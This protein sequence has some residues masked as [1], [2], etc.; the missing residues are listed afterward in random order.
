MIRA[1]RYSD[2]AAIKHIFD[3][4]FDDEYR[5]R[6]VDIVKR[7]SRWQQIYPL[8]RI[9]ALFPN[10][11]QDAFNVH[12]FD[13]DGEIRALIQ[14][15]ARNRERT[16]WHI[17]NVAVLP[18]FRGQGVAKKLLDFIFDHYNN[19]GVNRFTLEVDTK[20]ASALRLYEKTGFR[21]Y[22]TVNYY[23]L[24]SSKLTGQL[25]LA[26]DPV[27]VPEGF[28]PHK[29]SDAVQ[30][31]ELYKDSTPSNVRMVDERKLSDFKDH[32]LE[33]V[34]SYIKEQLKY[35]QENHWVVERDAKIVAS[36]EIVAQHRK[37]PH[38]LRLQM[39]PGYHDLYEP[40]LRF[41][42]HHLGQFPARSLL[43]ASL[44]HQGAKAEAM[45]AIGF[46]LITSDHL[47]VRDN[48]QVI[49]LAQ[50]DNTAIK[51]EDAVFKPIFAERN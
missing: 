49:T 33:E 9:L 11:Y 28:R 5:Q 13:E 42:M 36:M 17:E 43:G 25:K 4:A 20:N 16:T 35:C 26:T 34:S 10:P 14:P 39:H 45:Q 23:R 29:A 19:L 40:L 24:N 37:L 7:I 8:I 47:M 18:T 2:F 48:L 51:V 41:A 30:L 38:V 50:F 1:A 12:V 3:V 32:A 27:E 21:R 6:G 15:P 22:T 44:E 31:F 46:K